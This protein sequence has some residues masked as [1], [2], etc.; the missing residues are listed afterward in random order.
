M[1]SKFCYYIDNKYVGGNYSN[2]LN[3]KFTNNR[4]IFISSRSSRPPAHFKNTKNI[5]KTKF[6]GPVPRILYEFGLHFNYSF[7]YVHD[8]NNTYYDAI[9]RSETDIDIG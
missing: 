1:L 3:E 8:N 7:K 2:V 4:V 5:F 9:S 6:C